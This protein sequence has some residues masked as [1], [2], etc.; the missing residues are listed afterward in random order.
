MNPLYSTL[1]KVLCALF[2][3]VGLT[4]IGA[5]PAPGQGSDTSQQLQRIDVEAPQ[6]RPAP[7]AETAP[8]TDAD[9]DESALTSPLSSEDRTD[10]SGMFS[11]RGI[12]ASARSLV[13]GK[14]A[15]S[16]GASSLP[17]QVTTVTSQDIQRL[18]VR[19]LSDLFRKVPGINANWY[20]QGDIG[21]AFGMRGFVGQHGKDVATF[22]DGV[23]QNFPSAA[24]GSTGMMNLAW[25][26]PE[27]IERID[28]IKGPVSAL[29]GD[30]AL[31]G[32]VNIVTKKSEVSPTACASG[33]SFGYA[34]GLGVFSSEAWSPTP[35]LVNELY[36]IDGYRDNSQ[37]KKWNTFNKISFPLQ[38]G[39][40]S[41]RF[42]Y[43]T[44]D[45][46]APAYLAI[47]QVKAGLVSRR[48]AVD[49]TDGGDQ[50]RY[51]IVL[52]YAPRAGER[53][54]YATAYW[55]RYSLT[56]FGSNTG[57]QLAQ[58]DDRQYWGGRIYY[59]LV[60]AD[61]ANLTVGVESRRDSGE[62]LQY[63]SN[64][65]QRYNTRYD[66]ELGLRSYSWF[67]QSRIRLVEGLKIVGGVRG[68][69][70][71]ENVFN[72][73]KPV[74]S[75]E[76][77]PQKISP[78]IGIVI[79]PTKNFNIFGNVA[80]GLRSPSSTEMS[81]TSTAGNKD[82]GLPPAGI[83]TSDLGFNATL[84]GNLYL[85]ADYYHTCMEKEVQTINSQ[86]VAVG[87]TTRK[88]F[89]VDATFYPSENINVFANYAWV[90]AKVQNPVKAGRNLVQLVPEHIIKG[91]IHMERDFG[92]TRSVLADLYYQYYSGVPLYLGSTAVT[93]SYAP[94][95]DVYN[96]KLTYMGTGWSAFV[97]GKIQPREY[98]SQFI[99]PFSG[100]LNFDPQPKWTLTSE[101]TY[102]F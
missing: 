63:N 25:L 83:T 29:Y 85:A 62:A 59:N 60:F 99:G 77:Y 67:V 101:L 64:A 23:P 38:G 34:R 6:R 13:D 21:F 33:G 80:N 3:A 12:P 41:L 37:R 68:D 97:A 44:S 22:V 51:E 55:D 89:E 95:Y 8:R 74:N 70:F 92:P 15:V 47:D 10:P 78:K 56:R 66:Y 40:I 4:T 79:T 81:P 43:S 75:G 100:T 30:F 11:G 5:I 93:P 19:N 73:T 16:L 14:S 61:F 28:I 26:T 90:D 18:N 17:A 72:T 96:F 35:Y 86:Q 82:F 87:D 50:T 49:T 39:L 91:G 58:V 27:V 48:H 98:S 94:D 69:Y 31:A 53:G 42:N 102:T 9:Y 2:L 52:N 65:R 1:M 7:V 46:G 76:G 24:Q 32:A 88:G 36:T 57:S 20:G 54:F 71:R 84:F 45:W